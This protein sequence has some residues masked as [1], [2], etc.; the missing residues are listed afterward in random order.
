MTSSLSTHSS[1]TIEKNDNVRVIITLS[2]G[3][4]DT[5]YAIYKRFGRGRTCGGT[6]DGVHFVLA[7]TT[8][9]TYRNSPSAL[10]DVNIDKHKN[11]EFVGYYDIT[12]VGIG[13][14]TLSF[15]ESL[16]HAMYHQ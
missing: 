4:L 1:L 14:T 5:H 3:A 16:I 10:N 9:G 13:S 12:H 15:V 7:S 11:E 2:N 8:H 6:L